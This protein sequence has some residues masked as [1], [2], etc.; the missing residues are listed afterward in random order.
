[1]RALTD[2]R[3]RIDTR[4]LRKSY[5]GA[6]VVAPLDLTIEAG[7][8][9]TILGPSGCGKTTTL[10]MLAGFVAPSAGEVL[11]DGATVTHVRP[12]ARGVGVVF[13]NYALFPHMTVAENLAFPLE[14]RRVP[15][16]EIA[17]RV[18]AALE[19]VQLPY[20]DRYPAQLS[21]GQQQR[22]AVARAVIFNPPVL[23][24]DE[25]LGALDRKLR[26]HLQVELRRLQQRLGVT[27]VSVTH[28]QDEAMS[29]SDRIAVFNHGHLEQVGTPADLYETP[30]TLF[31]AQFLGD[32]NVLHGRVE[33][34]RSICIGG[35]VLPAPAH[36]LVAGNPVTVTVR[37][38]RVELLPEQADALS[39]RVTDA[40]F[41]GA[42][43]EYC[44][45]VAGLGEI[46]AITQNTGRQRRFLPGDSVAVAWRDTD[47]HLFAET[48]PIGGATSDEA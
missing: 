34:P 37:P 6:D 35:H 16:D 48:T 20:A 47:L 18:A 30:A 7:E 2:T 36:C 15:R 17:R 21:G 23:L 12:Q 41:L 13:Q 3:G 11:I 1:M 25:P 44:V 32:N 33:A 38:E 24:M 46:R 14:M 9:F 29:M 19:L 39:G 27:F 43:S 42:Q 4:R 40:V 22:V 10:M 45:D 28:D 31:V 5:G 26:T 8:F